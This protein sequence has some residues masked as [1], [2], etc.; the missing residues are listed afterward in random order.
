[1]HGAVEPI[2]RRYVPAG[3]VEDLRSD[4]IATQKVNFSARRRLKGS[5]M[6]KSKRKTSKA[7]ARSS[8][9]KPLLG[10]TDHVR[11]SKG[12]NV[13]AD[14]SNMATWVAMAQLTADC[15]AM[16]MHLAA[17]RSPFELWRLQA[18]LAHQWLIVMQSITFGRPLGRPTPGTLAAGNAVTTP[19][20]GQKERRRPHRTA[21]VGAHS[22]P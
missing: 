13:S 4:S 22:R 20:G 15:M 18:R 5:I 8:S 17:C 12:K 14:S 10:R 3:M 11:R 2:E 6:A 21:S 1:M 19:W 16:P 9:V 7:R